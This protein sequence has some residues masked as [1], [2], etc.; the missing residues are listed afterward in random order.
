MFAR[1]GIQE[2]L[3]YIYAYEFHNFDENDNENRLLPVVNGK[4]I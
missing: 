1:S 2:F 4:I 3:L